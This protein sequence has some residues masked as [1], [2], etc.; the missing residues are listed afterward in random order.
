MNASLPAVRLLGIRPLKLF[1]V[2]VDKKNL[3]NSISEISKT[4]MILSMI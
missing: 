3:E 1:E 2:I 4:Q